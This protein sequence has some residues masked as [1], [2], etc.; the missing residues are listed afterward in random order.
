MP[1]LTPPLRQYGIALSEFGHHTRRNT[2]IDQIIRIMSY[3]LG[4]LHTFGATPT[5]EPEYLLVETEFKRPCPLME[6]IVKE[7]LKDFG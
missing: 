7:S 6:L 1:V 3:D 5:L 4:P 2:V